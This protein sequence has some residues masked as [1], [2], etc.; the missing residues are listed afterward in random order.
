MSE[1]DFPAVVGRIGD[2]YDARPAPRS[3][4]N[5]YANRGVQLMEL[6]IEQDLASDDY[7]ST[8]E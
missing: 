7:F 5:R 3:N 2:Q 1:E 8:L 4:H 6:T